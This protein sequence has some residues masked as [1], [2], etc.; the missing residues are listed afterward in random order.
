MQIKN[1]LY[2]QLEDAYEKMAKIDREIETM[3]HGE[4]DD[5]EKKLDEHEQSFQGLME[6]LGKIFSGG[7]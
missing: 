5:I 3:T 1:K 2:D 6:L 4:F 7:A